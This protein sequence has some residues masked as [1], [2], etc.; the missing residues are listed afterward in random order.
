MFN[1]VGLEINNKEIKNSGSQ[2]HEVLAD[3]LVDILS[4]MTDLFRHGVSEYQLIS[5]LKNPPYSVFDDEA[6]RDPLV[7]FKTHFVLF[8]ALYCLRNQW[9]MSGIGELDIHALNIQLSAPTSSCDS[10]YK[11]FQKSSQKSSQDSSDDN[12]EPENHAVDAHDALASYY[13]NWSNFEETDKESVEALLDSFWT[14]MGHAQFETYT[15]HEIDDAHQVLGF[16]Y[17]TYLSMK[18]KASFDV[19]LADVKKHYRKKLQQQ[20]PDKGGSVEGA[21][22]VISAYRLLVKFYSFK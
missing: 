21:Q 5:K 15:D 17:T 11:S 1:E 8:H 22:R 9:R 12:D 16:S 13:L 10:A 3:L 14:Q 20:H 7:L 19:T 2:V 6:L 4:T 18:E